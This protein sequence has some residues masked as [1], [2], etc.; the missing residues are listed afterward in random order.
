MGGGCSFICWV[1]TGRIGGRE[2]EGDCEDYELALDSSDFVLRGGSGILGGRMKRWII[3]SSR[4]SCGMGFLRK[5]TLEA[6]SDVIDIW[7]ICVIMFC[8]KYF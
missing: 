5:I 6:S 7:L 3:S 4:P 2:D 8:V 1:F